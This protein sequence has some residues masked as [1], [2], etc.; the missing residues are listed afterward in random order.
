MGKKIGIVD[1]TQGELGTRGSS[2]KRRE[3]A[4]NASVS[5]GLSVRKNL[6]LKDGFFTSD[7]ASMLKIIT[8]IRRFRP[9]IVLANSLEDRHPDHGKAAKLVADAC[10]LAGLSKIETMDNNEI[11]A[12]YRPRLLLHYIQDYYI[13]PDIVLDVSPFYDQKIEAIKCY[14]S[15]FFDPNSTELGTP[16]SGEDF[17]DF[18]K[19]RMM[20]LGRPIGATYAEGFSKSRLL[21]TNDLFE[22]R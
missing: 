12:H 2:E 1:L 10:F 14:S 9:E 11:Q 15:Q 21:G 13:E 8:E 5:L 6:E 17:F 20:T 4:A 7:E 16:I 18:L 19:G 3:E 22:L